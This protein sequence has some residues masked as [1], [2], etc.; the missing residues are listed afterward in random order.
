ML[1]TGQEYLE[2]I[3]AVPKGFANSRLGKGL[4]DAIEE[5]QRIQ[6]RDPKKWDYGKYFELT[7][8]HPVLSRVPWAGKF[9]NIGPVEM[10]TVAT[11]PSA[12]R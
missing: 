3:R 4:M 6:G 1:L 10:S 2:S 7:F 12:S 5:G 9:L 11:A 8:S